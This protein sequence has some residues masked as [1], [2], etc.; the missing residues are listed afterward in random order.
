MGVTDFAAAWLTTTG[1][2]KCLAARYFG[3]GLAPVAVNP[4]SIEAVVL[5]RSQPDRTTRYRIQ[6][7]GYLSRAQDLRTL[8]YRAVSSAKMQT[9]GGAG[10]PDERHRFVR[11][12]PSGT[13]FRATRRSFFP[14]MMQRS[15][16]C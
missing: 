3:G 12:V 4:K 7:D 10:D 15:F 13:P 1:R 11:I 16:K 2:S 9:L 5:L 8:P 14:A 6:A